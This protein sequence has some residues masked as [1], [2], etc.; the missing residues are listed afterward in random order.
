MTTGVPPP[1]PGDCVPIP[2]VRAEILDARSRLRWVAETH[3]VA[4]LDLDGHGS[5]VVL[6]PAERPGLNQAS[7]WWRL[8]VR[9]G[10]CGHE[11]GIVVGMND[12]A[13][14]PGESHGLRN[15]SVVDSVPM[16]VGRG[17]QGIGATT[18]SFDGERYV[19]GPVEYR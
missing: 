2:Q 17:L 14:A 3:V 9:R 19:G 8:F 13:P 11:L 5:P 15:F 18:Y 4:D 7:M 1:L 10:D 16:N 12:P 6:V